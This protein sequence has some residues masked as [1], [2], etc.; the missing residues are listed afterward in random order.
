M[1]KL[2]GKITLISMI[3]AS[4]LMAKPNITILATG[5]TIAGSGDSAVKSSYSAG[6]VTVDKLLA[7]VPD[8]NK[9]ATIKGEQI[10]NIGSQEMSNKVWLKLAKR[11]NA[12]LKKDS[13]DGVVITHG[14][15]TMEATAYFLNLTVKSKKPIVLVGAMRSGSSM[16]ANGPLNLYNAVSVATSEKTSAKGVLVVMNDEIHSAREVTK[17]NTSAVNAFA[18]VNTGKIGTVY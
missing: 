11:V 12:L 6:A 17:T 8:I 7:A 5:G 13:V 14:T 1:T 10:S 3:G 18:S 4:F 15:D 2:L 9:M 16:S